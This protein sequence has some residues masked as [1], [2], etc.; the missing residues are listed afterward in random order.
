MVRFGNVLG[1]S[2]SVIP[3][4]TKQIK[5]NGPIT[6]TD[7]N[8]IRYFMTIPSAHAYKPPHGKLYQP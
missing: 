8:I 1:S 6:I 5:E 3:L 2:G 4:F 7:K